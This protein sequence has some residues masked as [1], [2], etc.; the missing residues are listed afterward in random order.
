MEN[1]LNQKLIMAVKIGYLEGVQRLLIEGA[2]PSWKD[3]DGASALDWIILFADSEIDKALKN[4][5]APYKESKDAHDK[6]AESVR[7]FYRGR[8]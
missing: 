3:E 5:M 6:W 1:N 8:T 2:N 4:S 7:E